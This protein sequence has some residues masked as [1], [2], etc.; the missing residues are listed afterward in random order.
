MVDS[1]IFH[2]IYALS[3][4]GDPA[5]SHPIAATVRSPCPVAASCGF[6]WEAKLYA[7]DRAEFG[8][9]ELGWNPGPASSLLCVFGQD[10]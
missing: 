1:A 3:K 9:R 6:A 8:V 4:K 10:T 7:G 2:G 5:Q